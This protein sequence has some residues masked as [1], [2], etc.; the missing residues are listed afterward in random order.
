MGSQSRKVTRL[1]K[2]IR[3]RKKIRGTASQPR[4][5]VFR[6]SK[7]IYAQLIN[8]EDSSTIAAAS[9]MDK[10]LTFGDEVKGKLGKANMVGKL[11]AERAIEKG[12]KKIVFD[13]SGFLYHGR[14]KSLSDGAREAGLDF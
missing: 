12:C 10:E 7:H 9:T 4:L 5:S 2:K 8:D 6:S 11:V 14:I 1:K 3:I 13:R